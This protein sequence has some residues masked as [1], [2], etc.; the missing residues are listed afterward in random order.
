MD[1]DPFFEE[2]FLSDLKRIISKNYEHCNSLLGDMIENLFVEIMNELN[3]IRIRVAHPKENF[4]LHIQK[5]QSAHHQPEKR[6]G[7]FI[8]GVRMRYLGDSYQF[9]SKNINE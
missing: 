6:I 2:L 8:E 5:D 1:I 9:S 7:S 4:S 3:R